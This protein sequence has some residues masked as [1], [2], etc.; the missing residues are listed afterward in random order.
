[1]K[2]LYYLFFVAAFLIYSARNGGF[3]S[4]LSQWKLI[5]AAIFII[6]PI[7]YWVYDRFRDH[8]K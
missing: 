4:E 6:I 7:G 3:Y 8:R 2:S 1:M 5:F